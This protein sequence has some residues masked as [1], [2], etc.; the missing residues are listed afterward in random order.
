MAIEFLDGLPCNELKIHGKI[1]IL[2]ACSAGISL[3]RRDV[4]EF[5]DADL[6]VELEE[7]VRLC[8]TGCAFWR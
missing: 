2:W 3:A 7:G 5:A 6:F 4:R 1:S 8:L